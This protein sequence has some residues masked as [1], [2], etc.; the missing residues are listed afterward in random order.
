MKVILDRDLCNGYGNCVMEAPEAFDLDDG[1]I[2]IVLLESPAP[3]QEDRVRSAAAMC[4][5]EAIRFED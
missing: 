4:P 5:V 3:D 1:G 2:G